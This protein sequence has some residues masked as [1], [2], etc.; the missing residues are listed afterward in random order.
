MLYNIDIFL[1]A[2]YAQHVD[3]PP[4]LIREE[5]EPLY[6]NMLH[7]KY[8]YNYIRIKVAHIIL[9][10]VRV[11]REGARHRGARPSTTCPTPRAH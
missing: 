8:I 3:I 1:Y 7:I 4:Y 6:M 9:C 5:R 2:S 11:P 10:H